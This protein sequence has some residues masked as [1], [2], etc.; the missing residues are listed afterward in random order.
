MQKSKT[1]GVL[2]PFLSGYTLGDMNLVIQGIE[3]CRSYED[4][5]A[6]LEDRPQFRKLLDVLSPGLYELFC[7]N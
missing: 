6:W 1:R 2:C 7:L 5:V 3:K 4:A